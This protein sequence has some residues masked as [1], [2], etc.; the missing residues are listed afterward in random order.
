MKKQLIALQEYL[1]QNGLDAAYISSPED[2][3]YFTGFYSDPV[4]RILA[5]LVFPDKDPFMF[6]PQLEVEAAKDAGWDKDVFGY[7]DHEDPFAL[8]AGHIKDV[9]GSPVNWGI[10][11]DNMSVQKLEAL[12]QQFPDAKFPVNLSRYM[13]NAKLIKTP[14]EIAELKA[15]GDE[16]DF[17]F[18]VAFKAI[19]EGR[20][21]QE[22]V[23]EIEYAMMKKGVMHMSFDTIVQAGANAANPHGGPE[24]TPIKRDELI[25]FDLGTVHNGYISDSSRTV[26]FG[27][28]DA[29]SLDIYKVDL[30]AQYAA[31]DA[32]KPGITAAELDKVARDI[33]TKAGYGEYFIHRLGHG[34]GASEH[35]FPSIME[36]NDMELKPGMCFSIEPGIYIPNVAGVRIEDCV[37]ITEDGC[38][39]FTHTSKELQYID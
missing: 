9:A 23:A 24:K 14:E 29:K 4:E 3:N 38:E 17:A 21:E 37:Y 31:M 16:A 15:A 26:A 39:P 1:A 25:L 6:A 12:R 10:E 27:Q 13:E 28:P 30:E 2:I 8:M 34:M 35:E 18:S 5:L 32:A 7:L 11:K 20:T 36:G 22:V 33:I 19:K